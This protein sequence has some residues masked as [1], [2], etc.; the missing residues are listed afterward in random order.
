MKEK[1]INIRYHLDDRSE[2]LV[3]NGEEYFPLHAQVTFNRQNTKFAVP[4]L[5]ADGSKI[6]K[7]QFRE[8][9]ESNKPSVLR[10]NIDQLSDLVKAIIR[11]EYEN[12]GERF[13]I[14]GIIKKVEH[15]ERS[16][17]EV[18]EKYISTK[19]W[20]DLSTYLTTEQLDAA[21]NEFFDPVNTIKLAQIY[22]EDIPGKMSLATVRMI[23]SYLLISAF[24]LNADQV[25]YVKDWLQA[26]VRNAFKKF[27][28]DSDI[29]QP[30]MYISE[31]ESSSSFY[32]QFVTMF[33]PEKVDIPIYIRTIDS[34][35]IDSFGFDY[36][37]D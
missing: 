14:K 15:Y 31:Q 17:I 23:K 9:F 29:E 34:M 21:A 35:V 18:I 33:I 7:T 26:D 4:T 20:S 30:E 36:G 27:L 25:L 28:L 5:I 6:S 19:V 32:R 16:M 22:V 2:P 1:R 10:D 8:V 12:R 13:R 11:F 24:P 37:M 3:M